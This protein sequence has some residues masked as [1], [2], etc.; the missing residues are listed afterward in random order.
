[1]AFPSFLSCAILVLSLQIKGSDAV[2]IKK[3]A[4]SSGAKGPS[5]PEALPTDCAALLSE[6]RGSY[7]FGP[8]VMQLGETKVTAWGGKSDSEKGQDR[9]LHVCSEN[10]CIFAIMD[11]HGGEPHKGGAFIAQK[12]K[13][14]LCDRL[15]RMTN[16][17][18]IRTELGR[19]SIVVNRMRDAFESGSTLAGVVIQEDSFVVFNAGDSPVIWTGDDLNKGILGE[20]ELHDCRNENEIQRIRKFR[21]MPK[22]WSPC[23]YYH[24]WRMRESGTMT[25]RG[26]GN[27]TG[28][29]FGFSNEPAVQT[30]S[31]PKPDDKLG[32]HWFILSSDGILSDQ[33]DDFAMQLSLSRTEIVKMVALGVEEDTER[34]SDDALL[35]RIEHMM[36]IGNDFPFEKLPINLQK[37]PTKVAEFPPGSGKQAHV[38]RQRILEL[39]PALPSAVADDSPWRPKRGDGTP[40]THGNGDDCSILVIRVN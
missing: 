30:L 20:T 34:G 32:P 22:S 35:G 6:S 12:V 38:L 13:E 10:R 23:Y 2:R 21:R 3:V 11:G 14:L 7:T 19:I 40:V 17:A 27:S 37:N 24:G 4:T 9:E 33:N 15:P 25:T 36:R 16:E 28:L 29:D 18:S 26:F 8:Q 1:M 5:N 39:L 31:V